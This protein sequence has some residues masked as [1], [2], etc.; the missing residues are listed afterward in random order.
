MYC[1]FLANCYGFCC[2]ASFWHRYFQI[3]QHVVIRVGLCENGKGMDVEYMYMYHHHKQRGSSTHSCL[4]WFLSDARDLTSAPCFTDA[5][6]SIGYAG[7]CHLHVLRYFCL[8][9]SHQVATKEM[10]WQ[11]H[12]NGLT[13][14]VL[15]ILFGA[16]LFCATYQSFTLPFEPHFS[17]KIILLSVN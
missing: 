10:R 11:P 17:D 9:I 16:L 2:S 13:L 4:Q 5:A 6:S 8:H 1:T 12:G 15:E 3:V 7:G 14:H